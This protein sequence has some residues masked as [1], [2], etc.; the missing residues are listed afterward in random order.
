M[1]FYAGFTVS[2]CQF[3]RYNLCLKHVKLSR[4]CVVYAYYYCASSII[5]TS[6]IRTSIIRTPNLFSSRA[7]FNP[8][9]RGYK[10]MKFS[11]C[12]QNMLWLSWVSDTKSIIFFSAVLFSSVMP[13]NFPF[14]GHGKAS[15]DPPRLSKFSAYPN[16]PSL[17]W[18]QPVRIIEDAL[19][20][21]QLES[22]L[23]SIRQS[24]KNHTIFGVLIRHF[25]CCWAVCDNP[26]EI[27][28]FYVHVC[29]H[30]RWET[31]VPSIRSLTEI[32]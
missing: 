19:Y 20:C 13:K 30:G 12:W 31:S 15:K 10:L 1:F 2:N 5:R 16:C 22:C 28:I 23:K 25:V 24:W 6:I 29:T 14:W 17:N 18:V 3:T 7:Q 32:N 4:T 26:E 8:Y 21:V 27:K 11:F 9:F